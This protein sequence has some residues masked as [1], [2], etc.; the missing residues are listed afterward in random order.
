MTLTDQLSQARATLDNLDAAYARRQ[1]HSASVQAWNANKPDGVQG[2][3]PI[4][5]TGERPSV[6]QLL[7]AEQLVLASV[8]A[9]GAV[10][11]ADAAVVAARE[12]LQAANAR[13]KVASVEAERVSQHLVPA[14]RR[15][16]GDEASKSLAAMGDLEGLVVEFAGEDRGARDPYVTVSYNG[17]PFDLLS[18]GERVLACL[19]FRRGLRRAAKRMALPLAVDDVVQL[20]G[21]AGPWPVV[22]GASI[23]MVTTTATGAP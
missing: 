17:V 23:W 4:V 16:P 21:G 1:A 20:N 8:R 2:P 13:A 9:G 14:T 12:D 11:A 15:A 6:E 3:R 22:E 10:Q 19:L 7:A 5:P 18:G